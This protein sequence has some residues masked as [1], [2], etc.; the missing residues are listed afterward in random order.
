MAYT[1]TNIETYHPGSAW[2]PDS[3]PEHL[4]AL[5]DDYHFPEAGSDKTD[6][7][8]EQA[9]AKALSK[10]VSQVL[11]GDDTKKVG[12]SRA[13]TAISL[14]GGNCIA[15][16][17][18]GTGYAHALDLDITPLIGKDVPYGWHA[19]SLWLGKTA[20]WEIDYYFQE[21]AEFA[22]Y[23]EAHNGIQSAAR[24]ALERG[25][26]MHAR[27]VHMGSDFEIFPVISEDGLEPNPFITTTEES[28]Q[29]RVLTALP[30]ETGIH[31]LKAFADYNRYLQ[32]KPERIAKIGD[33]ILSFVPHG[34][35]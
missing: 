25:Q 30:Y 24:Q 20:I 10:V 4:I 7:A 14:G 28:M 15:H 1:D 8:R 17:E 21:F 2:A 26:G 29:A 33:Q 35:S 27:Y 13:E 22:P 5:A 23:S 6:W 9:L 12:I 32:L 16:T 31:M 18:I 19:S 34:I 3:I 11:T